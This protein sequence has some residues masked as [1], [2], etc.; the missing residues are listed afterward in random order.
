ML[1]LHRVDLRG[2]HLELISEIVHII[3]ISPNPQVPTGRHILFSGSLVHGLQ[4]VSQLVAEGNG[5]I[6][7]FGTGKAERHTRLVLE[8]VNEI[9]LLLAVRRVDLVPLRVLNLQI[10][11]LRT[12]RPKRPDWSNCPS[13]PRRMRTADLQFRPPPRCT[14]AFL[15]RRSWLVHWRGPKAKARS[16]R[17]SSLST[18]KPR[19]KKKLSQTGLNRRPCG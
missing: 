15:Q 8:V 1:I 4:L 16:R 10:T 14:A 3:C 12:E 19:E 6:L 2:N 7:L 11:L 13:S 17:C 9:V 18:D 5:D